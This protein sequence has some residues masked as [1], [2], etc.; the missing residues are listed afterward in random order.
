[1]AF[2]WKKISARL[3][4]E[5]PQQS[6]CGKRAKTG[7]GQG[8]KGLRAK[9]AILGGD[10]RR[11]TQRRCRSRLGAPSSGRP[12]G[13]AEAC[14]TRSHRA[15]AAAHGPPGAAPPRAPARD[16][17]RWGRSAA[18]HASDPGTTPTHCRAYRATPRHWPGS[19][20]QGWCARGIRP[21]DLSR[22]YNFH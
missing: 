5:H 4:R 18:R 2:R 19:I 1:M 17:H 8:L 9:E 6:P 22:R 15:A 16:G 7:K 12:S 10:S 11:G 14:R 3:R 21:L 20:P 13:R